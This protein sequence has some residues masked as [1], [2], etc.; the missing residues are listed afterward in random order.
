MC[1]CNSTQRSG[2]GE[3]SGSRGSHPQPGSGTVCPP[4][5]SPTPPGGTAA[6]CVNCSVSIQERPSFCVFSPA[7]GAAQ[8]VTLHAVGRDPGGTYTWV[9]ANPN[10]AHV[11]GAGSTATVTA[12]QPGVTEIRVNYLCPNGATTHDT[13]RCIAWRAAINHPAGDPVAAGAAT[14]EFTFNAAVPGLLNIPCRATITPNN[15]EAIAC[16]N[17]HLRWTID[18]V[19]TSPLT[20]SVPDPGN[21]QRGKGRDTTAT[22]TGLPPHNNDFGAKHVTL[23]LDTGTVIGT[24]TI[25]VFFSKNATNHPNPGQGVSPNWFFYWLQV[26]G[27]PAHVRYGGAGPGGLF[28]ETRGMTQWSYA[29]VPDKT[30]VHVFDTASTQDGAIPGLHGP[31]TGIDLF[32]NTVLHESEHA[33]QI[34]RADP[35]VGIHAG[36]C[37]RFGWS[38]NVGNHNHWTLGAGRVAGGAGICTTVGPGTMGTDPTDVDLSAVIATRPGYNNW[39]TAW[40]VPVGAAPGGAFIGGSPIEQQAFQKE[41]S[42]EHALAR[43]DWSDPGKNHRTLNRFND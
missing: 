30:L 23:L 22:F 8:S 11:V 41:T 36:T 28:G 9:A 26:S 25:E 7:A 39:P 42:A 15:A 24:T 14:N 18:A 38:W 5:N 29:A 3:G 20:W 6:H 27:N 31:L 12:V 43:Q 4:P 19:G 1:C 33:D 2:S 35:I 40:G 17:E 21:A 10:I 32:H 13:V 37:W 16:A 34:A